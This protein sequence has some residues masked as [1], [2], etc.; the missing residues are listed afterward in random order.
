MNTDRS[1]VVAGAGAI[2]CLVGGMLAVADRRVALLVRP[3]VKAEIERFGL[4]LTGFD[5]AEQ[6]V[7]E[8]QITLSDDPSIFNT[9]WV[10]LVTV[11]SADTAEMAD[12]IA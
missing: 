5:G 11:K 4:R 9:A 1:I 2:G 12:V 7:G 6:R 3:R 10:V 8:S